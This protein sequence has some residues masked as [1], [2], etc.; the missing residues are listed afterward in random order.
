MCFHRYQNKLI[1][2]FVKG[3]YYIITKQINVRK[4]NRKQVIIRKIFYNNCTF[5]P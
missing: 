3:K 2:I 1:I 5:A 4:I